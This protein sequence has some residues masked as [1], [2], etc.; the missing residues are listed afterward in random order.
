MNSTMNSDIPET[1]RTGRG[2]IANQDPDCLIC[3]ELFEAATETVTHRD[4]GKSMCSPCFFSWMRTTGAADVTCPNC[5]AALRSGQDHATEPAPDFMQEM[6]DRWRRT[7]PSLAAGFQVRVNI[8]L[9]AQTAGDTMT[10]IERLHSLRGIGWMGARPTLV[11]QVQN[12]IQDQFHARR[13]MVIR[14]LQYSDWQAQ[15]E[16]SRDPTRPR[17]TRL[18]AAA[19][20]D[21]EQ[22]REIR[23]RA[24]REALQELFD[25]FDSFA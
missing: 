2:P 6:I 20:R 10:V 7:Q 25:I 18:E 15:D 11:P 13:Q 22:R 3:Q 4:C 19:D 24:S 12:A 8:A 9:A 23:E 5:R 21:R 14:Q 16:L 1:C 17:R